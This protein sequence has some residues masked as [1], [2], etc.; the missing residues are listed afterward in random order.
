MLTKEKFDLYH[1][2]NPHIYQIF[3]RFTLEVIRSGR[4]N[5]GIG[6]IA[7]RCR[8]YSAIESIGDPFKINNNYRAFY[9]RLFEAKN[10]QYAGF[11]R[12]RASVADG[13]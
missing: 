3:E 12:K 5:F 1:A 9:A 2:E 4:K 6:A 7:E 13:S 11:F 10:P 8:W